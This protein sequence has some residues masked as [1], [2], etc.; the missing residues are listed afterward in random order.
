MEA[1]KK[2]EIS[3]LDSIQLNVMNKQSQIMELII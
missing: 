2:Q 1:I 3:F